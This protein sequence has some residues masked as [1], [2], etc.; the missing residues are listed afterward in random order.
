MKWYANREAQTMTAH[1]G[2]FLLIIEKR[3]DG[4]GW[5]WSI[6]ADDDLD[7]PARS[8]MGISLTIGAALRDVEDALADIMTELFELITTGA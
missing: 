3:E 4:D 2:V 6:G 1:E 8:D 7:D 5:L